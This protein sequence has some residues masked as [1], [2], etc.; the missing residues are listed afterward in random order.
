MM[1]HKPQ[2]NLLLFAR[3]T[4]KKTANVVTPQDL[5]ES[6]KREQLANAKL[7]KVL[8]ILFSAFSTGFTGGH[9]GGAASV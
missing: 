9:G 1:E 8:K 7:H 5:T 2:L 3:A 6:K 4:I